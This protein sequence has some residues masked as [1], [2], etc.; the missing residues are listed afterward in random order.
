MKQH[1]NLELIIVGGGL[2][3]AEAA[4]QA[5]A[6]GITVNLYEMR[7]IQKTGA[8]QSSLLAELVCS[9]SLGSNYPDRAA[10]I[11][12]NELR[13]LESL[14]INCADKAAVPAGGALAVDRDLFSHLVTSKIEN[15]PLINIIHQEI[16]QIPNTTSIIA[17]GPLT[18]P[19]LSE[20]I[21]NLTGYEQIFFYDALA[22]IIYKE[23]IDMDIAFQGSRYGDNSE[24]NGGDYLNCPMNREEYYRFVE[25]MINAEQINLNDNE[26][27]ITL[28]VRAGATKY[29]EGCLPIEIS[30]MRGAESLAYGPLRPVGLTDSR[31][32]QK[33]FAVVQLRQDN[34][35]KTLYNMVGFQTNLKYSEQKRIFRMIP[36]L[37]RVEFARYGQ[38]HRN[39][40]IFSPALLYPT[41]QFKYRNNLFFAGQITGIEG[42]VGSIAAGFL[43]GVNAARFLL[44]QTMLE[45]PAS[46]MIGAL[47]NYITH[48]DAKDF[49]PMKANL[50]IL[51]NLKVEING[52]RMRA[53]AYAHRSQTELQTFLEDNR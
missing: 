30:A 17:S 26:N 50:G 45:M 5:A 15:H 32:S 6:R 41:L 9:N 10:G 34:L 13:T 38:M 7:P 2:A 53:A 36:G 23:T 35:A 48:A 20:A 43:A 29:F 24:E 12:K 37:K 47:C 46:T 8:H 18:S 40:F 3:G 52:K 31:T 33:S 11:L 42:Y 49:Q 4:W 39:T 27:Q 51:P 44:G 22:P 19:T 25:E 21:Q 14:L 16:T 28:G 1:L